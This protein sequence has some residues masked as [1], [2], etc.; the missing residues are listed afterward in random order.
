MSSD[1]TTIVTTS[2]NGTGRGFVRGPG[3]GWLIELPGWRYAVKVAASDTGGRLTVLEGTMAPGH[4]GPLEHVH[5]GHDE[6]FTVLE[7]TLRFRIGNDYR[8]VVAGETVFTSRGLAHGFS[9]P[10]YTP[11]RFLVMLTP[12]G[13]ETYFERLAG[14]IKKSGSM[15]SRDALLKLMAE[16]GTF[17]VDA[18]GTIIPR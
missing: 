14:M 17:P 13:Y 18:D 15:P 8:D 10:D 4:Q 1:P 5:C 7:G 12:S 9:N 6:A 2:A 16:H 3:D 11:V